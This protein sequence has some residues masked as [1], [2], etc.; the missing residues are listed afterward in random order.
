MTLPELKKPRIKIVGIEE[1]LSDEEIL[2]ALKSQNEYLANSEMKVCNMFKTKRKNFTSIVEID[3]NSFEKCME[4]KR[5]KIM[6]SNCLVCEDLNVFRCYNC[7]GYNHKKAH[8]TN[9][10]TCRRCAMNHEYKVCNANMELCVNCKTAN[11]KFNLRLNTN[12]QAN[13]DKCTVYLK[14]VE[15]ER[16]KIKYSM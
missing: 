5:V 16:R 1:E 2:K 13:S 4:T 15:A 11:E 3:S 7:N 9:P 8:C 12:H 14:K 6:W 10:Q